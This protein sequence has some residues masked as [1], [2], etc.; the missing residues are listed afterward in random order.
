MISPS[1][2]GSMPDGFFWDVKIQQVGFGLFFG[3]VCAVV[4]T[5]LQ[6][7]LNKNRNRGV[8]WTIL[9]F[10]WLGIKFLFYAVNFAII[11]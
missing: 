4:F 7:T 5:L 9:I 3:F 1:E 6:N 11:S 10:T 8:S 2:D